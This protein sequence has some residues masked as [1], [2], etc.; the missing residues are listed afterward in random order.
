MSVAD[1]I[2]LCKYVYVRPALLAKAKERFGD[3]AIVTADWRLDVEDRDWYVSSCPVPVPEPCRE[4]GCVNPLG[5][6]HPDSHAFM[7]EQ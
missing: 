7:A 5:D 3:D 4:V 2:G 6:K 1:L